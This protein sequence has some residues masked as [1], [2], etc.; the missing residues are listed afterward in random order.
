VRNE[1]CHVSPRDTVPFLEIDEP[2]VTCCT[3]TY[4]A[5]KSPNDSAF[6]DDFRYS[7]HIVEIALVA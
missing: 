6:A 4:Q 2:M 7:Q 3:E 1:F 5:R